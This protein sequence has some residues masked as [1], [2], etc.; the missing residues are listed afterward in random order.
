MSDG[1]A[2][3]ALLEEFVTNARDLLVRADEAAKLYADRNVSPV[4]AIMEA[5]GSLLDGLVALHRALRET[6]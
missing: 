6:L 5:A 3:P 2:L 4:A 1:D